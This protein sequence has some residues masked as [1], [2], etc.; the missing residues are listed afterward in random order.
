ME[1]LPFCTSIEQQ[2][3]STRISLALLSQG[4][5]KDNSSLHRRIFLLD[6]AQSKVCVP[7]SPNSQALLP[8]L[9]DVARSGVTHAVSGFF[10]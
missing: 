1:F 6:P 5:A 8:W 4:S 10:P 2:L 9:Q 7:S 3:R